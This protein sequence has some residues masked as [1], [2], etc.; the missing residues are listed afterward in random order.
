MDKKNEDKLYGEYLAEL[1]Y[2]ILSA[3]YNSQHKN[4]SGSISFKIKQFV[5]KWQGCIEN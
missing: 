3:T 1:D 2:L 5:K 4:H